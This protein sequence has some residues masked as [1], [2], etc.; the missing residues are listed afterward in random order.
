MFSRK[1]L[2]KI[3]Q[4]RLALLLAKYLSE[5]QSDFRQERSTAYQI[6]LK[7]AELNLKHIHW[8]SSALNRKNWKVVKNAVNMISVN[9][10][11]SKPKK[12]KPTNSDSVVLNYQYY[13]F[14]CRPSYRVNLA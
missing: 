2:D 6:D 10:R 4:G 13:R 7:S 9:L 1:D 12:R 11:K 8:E 3:I 5:E 14:V